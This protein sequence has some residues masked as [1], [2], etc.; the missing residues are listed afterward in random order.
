[1]DLPVSFGFNHL[2]QAQQDSIHNLQIRVAH[3]EDDEEGSKINP[4]YTRLVIQVDLEENEMIK[5]DLSIVSQMIGA[6]IT[7]SNSEICSKASEELDE[8]KLGLSNL[9]YTLKTS[10]IE[11]GDT[12]LEMD[13][14]ESGKS[15]PI[16]SSVDLGV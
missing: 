15:L 2:N 3:Q 11:L 13:L 10:K 1:M 14:N 9:G 4:N 7:G 12:V 6:D 16:I 5:V 8:L